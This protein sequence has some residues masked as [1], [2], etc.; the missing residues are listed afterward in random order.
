MPAGA[1]RPREATYAWRGLTPMRHLFWRV[2][3]GLLASTLAVR[4]LILILKAARLVAGAAAADR[5]LARIEHAFVY[6]GW[7]VHEPVWINLRMSS[8][9]RRIRRGLDG[10]H[11]V[12]SAVPWRA[13]SV[14]SPLRV[15]C[16]GPFSGALGFPP[17]LFRLRPAGVHLTVIDIAYE[18]RHAPYLAQS[19]DAYVAGH[20]DTPAGIAAVATEV[21]AAG[22][23]LL[24]NVNA[25]SSAY[26]MLDRVRTP[27]IVNYCAG[28]DLLHHPRVGVQLHAQ[29]Q[30]DYFVTRNRMFCGMTRQVM[31][32]D[33]V[34]PAAVLYDRRGIDLDAVR[35]WRARDPLIVFHGSL[36]KIARPDVLSALFELLA[37]DQD[38]EC[39]FVGKERRGEGTRIREAAARCGVSSRVRVVAPFQSLRGEQGAV[40]DPGWTDTKALLQRARLAPDPWPVGGGAARAEAYALGVPTVHMG[41]RFEPE[42]WGRPQLS[43]TELPAL[44]TQQGTAWSVA[45]YQ[46]LCRRCL[47]GEVFAT[48]LVEEQTA[49]VRRVMDE[50]RWWSQLLDAYRLWETGN[51]SPAHG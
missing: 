26:D 14:D 19:A 28:A 11:P 22:L 4:G 30:A 40:D 24:L 38:R 36:F 9:F 41:V 35:P 8:V 50:G 37:E 15:G 5:W 25:R 31:S 34:V 44:L 47:T 45:Q 21:N 2:V 13:R 3:Y 29:P 51:R 32:D 16:V 6:S 27:C 49:L 1:P 42:H 43:L 48:R 23:D 10:P 39:V 17:D 33:F 20:L 12:V 7:P 18:G 46:D